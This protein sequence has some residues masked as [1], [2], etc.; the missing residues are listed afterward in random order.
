MHI[1]DTGCEACDPGAEYYERV[2]H[3]LWI[4]LPHTCHKFICHAMPRKSISMLP[5][6]FRAAS[7]YWIGV[8]HSL[9][10]VK[11]VRS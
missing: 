10:P 7:I 11:D 3:W 4:I 8:E 6:T 5:I 1:Q 2:D 9:S